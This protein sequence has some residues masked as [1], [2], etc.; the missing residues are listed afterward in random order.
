MWP[1]RC[2]V[3]RWNNIVLNCDAASEVQVQ[4]RSPI[5]LAWIRLDCSNQGHLRCGRSLGAIFA[6]TCK[7]QPYVLK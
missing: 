6:S 1:Y 3:M 4:L 7:D 2:D 5:G